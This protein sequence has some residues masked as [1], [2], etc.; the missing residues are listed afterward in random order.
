MSRNILISFIGSHDLTAGKKGPVEQLINYLKPRK[1]YLFLTKEYKEKFS[2]KNLKEYYGSLLTE[3]LEVIETDIINPVDYEEITQKISEKIEEINSFMLE[4]KFDGFLNLT[5]GT[6]VILSVL[7]LFAITGKLNRTAGLYA[8]NPEHD[9]KIKTNS[10][11]YYKNSFAFKTI[12]KLINTCSYCAIEALLAEEKKI[13]PKLF[14]NKEF[15]E[16]ISFAKNRSDCAFN[17]AYKIWEK[18]EFLKKYNYNEPK[19]LY[20]KSI[21]CLMT[22][23]ISEMNKDDFQTVLRLGLI[24]ENLLSYLLDKILE[25]KNLDIIEIKKTKKRKKEES[26]KLLNENKIKEKCPKLKEYIENKMKNSEGINKKVDYKR[27]VSSFMEGIILEYFLSDEE[28]TAYPIQQELYKLEELR[29]Q[30][31]ESAHTIKASKYNKNWMRSIEKIIKYTAQY[32]GFPEPDINI[33]K[34]INADLL[35]I[36]KKTIN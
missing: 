29:T 22:A 26:V 36:L 5:S 21:E 3:E 17:E 18:S 28:F 12:K 27:E 25:A 4:N 31:N 33:Y 20:E 10:L 34:K 24:R 11:D 9:N 13:L 35:D 15:K 23:K 2:Q 16:L 19:N 32:F 14:E 30:R 1:T 6:P 7:S 8:P